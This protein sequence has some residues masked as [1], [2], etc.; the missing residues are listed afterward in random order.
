MNS[1][2]RLAWLLAGLAATITAIAGAGTSLWYATSF[3]RHMHSQSQTAS[4]AAPGQ[5]TVRLS[6]GDI[7]VTN[8]PSGRV[9]VTRL[10][11]WSGRKPVAGERRKGG[12]LVISQQCPSGFGDSCSADYTIEVPPGV[13]LNLQT[14]S[15]DITAN[16]TRSP[17]LQASS[18]SGNIWLRFAAAP[19][20]VWANSSSGDV[21]V[22]VPRGTGYTIHPEAPNGNSTVDIGSD[23]ATHRSIT[24]ISGDGNI[25]VNYN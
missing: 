16:D 13:A 4:Y 12:T 21:T 3:G 17:E 11:H 22:L 2:G 7:T 9:Q 25:T 14:S 5:V 19:Y 24:A 10:L 6:D 23:P 1:R 20:N 18:D 15:G 8:G